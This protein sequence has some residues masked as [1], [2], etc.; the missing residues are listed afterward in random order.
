M[1][2][3]E[4][5]VDDKKLVPTL[6]SLDGL[7]LN[8][9]VQP[10]AGAQTKNGKVQATGMAHE[11]LLQTLHAQRKKTFTFAEAGVIVAA[12]GF[13]KKSLG[14]ATTRMLSEKLIRRKSRGIYEVLK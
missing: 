13:S 1:F 14:S 5:F 3:I 10:V 8:L 12:A 6:K 9:S 4:F 11:V 7:A 2:R